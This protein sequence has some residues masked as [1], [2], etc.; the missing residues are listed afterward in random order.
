MGGYYNVIMREYDDAIMK[1]ATDAQ[2]FFIC[3]SVAPYQ[4]VNYHINQFAN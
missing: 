4:L 3:A 1:K 2:I